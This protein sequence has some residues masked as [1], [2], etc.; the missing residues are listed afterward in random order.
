MTI[1]ELLKEY[2]ISQ[3]KNQKEFIDR[4][5]IVSQS[6]YSK[7]E[8]NV[9]RITADSLI[10]L[11][12]YNNIPLW[13]F[14]SRFNQGDEMRHQQIQ[15]LHDAMI[16]AYY[17][18]DEHRLK[19]VKMLIDE[20]DLSD[21]NKEEQ[22]LIVDGWLES[23]KKNPETYNIELR[24]NLKDKVFNSHN[25]D[26]STITLYCNFMSFYDLNSNRS[27]A[28]RIIRQYSNSSNIDIQI[29]L[30]AVIGNIL[31]LS[32]EKHEINKTDFFINSAHDIPTRP[33]LFFYKNGIFIFENLIRYLETKQKE[34]L[35]N[36]NKGIETLTNLDMKTYGSKVKA[37]VEKNIK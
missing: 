20:C 26:K 30:L 18:H 33:E 22:K 16:T 8:K 6:Y 34:Y 2:R 11:L 28:Q 5:R 25:Y 7:V 37:F 10:E 23:M 3:G 1:G 17:E 21:Q 15:D 27:I 29:S 13:E 31:A 14:F 9:H 4:G 12:H 24:N 32:I 19:N 36:C 35:N